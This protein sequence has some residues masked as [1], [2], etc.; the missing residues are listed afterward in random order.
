MSMFGSTYRCEQLFS[1]MKGNKSPIRSRITDVHLGSVLK[2][3]TAN[4]ISPEVGKMVTRNPIVF[5]KLPNFSSRKLPRTSVVLT[6]K[7]FKTKATN[8][9]SD[10]L[11]HWLLLLT[12]WR[13]KIEDSARRN[14]PRRHIFRKI[15]RYCVNVHFTQEV[16]NLIVPDIKDKKDS[17]FNTRIHQNFGEVEEIVFIPKILKWFEENHRDNDERKFDFE[18]IRFFL[19]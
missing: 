10:F 2:L 7:E 3:I 16:D 12:K 5:K 1:L 9:S 15:K 11:P 4:K 17:Q 8:L 14:S 19:N 13:R 18:E 6:S